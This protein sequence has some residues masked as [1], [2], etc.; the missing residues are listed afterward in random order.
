MVHTSEDTRAVALVT[1]AANNIGSA[2]AAAFA[3]DHR[4]VLADLQDATVVAEEIG[5]DAVAV[6][7]D[8]SE[9]ADCEGWIEAAERLGPL[10]VVV[11]SAGI[12]WPAKSI[13]EMPIE[14]WEA[15][16]RVNLNGTFLLMKAAIPALRRAGEGAAVLI[17]SRAGKTGFAALAANPG[18]TKAHY[19]ASKAGVISLTKSL[20]MELA[21]DRIRVNCVAPGPI[22]GAMIPRHQW[23]EISSR[24]PLGR[25]G[26]PEEIAAAVRFLCSPGAAFITGH[27]LDVNGGTLMD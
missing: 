1:G 5:N 27:V 15:T 24:V 11:H 23:E 16:I 18:A 13:E 6:Q 7:G 12:T 2:I 10:R 9:V 19:A 4:V 20:A 25:L 21:P 8:V 22:E 26:K 14:E 3:A 17:S